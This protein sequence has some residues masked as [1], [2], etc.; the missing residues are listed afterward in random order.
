MLC[1][2]P[3]FMLEEIRSVSGIKWKW[4]KLSTHVCNC[5]QPG[6]PAGEIWLAG[7]SHVNTVFQK[8]HT[9]HVAGSTWKN[10]PLEGD[11]EATVYRCST[12]TLLHNHT[13]LLCQCRWLR[14]SCINLHASSISDLDYL[15]YPILIL[16]AAKSRLFT[17]VIAHTVDPRSIHGNFSIFDT[18]KHNY[19]CVVL[20]SEQLPTL[21]T[22][23]R[24]CLLMRLIAGRGWREPGRLSSP[25]GQMNMDSRS[26]RL[27]LHRIAYPL[28]YVTECHTSLR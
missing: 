26:R 22:C 15:D 17:I 2:S 14:N 16:Y 4:L 1:N 20:L 25:R 3:D 19:C 21:A 18:I 28:S 12:Q 13:D 24:Q 5:R 6:A 7:I 8:K 23:T 10:E 9:T 27:Q 11:P